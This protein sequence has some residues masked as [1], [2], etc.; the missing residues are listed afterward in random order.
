M[1]RILIATFIVLSLA[2]CKQ[3]GYV[4]TGD[5]LAPDQSLSLREQAEAAN[6]N[7]HDVAFGN[8]GDAT[9]LLDDIPVGAIIPHFG[10]WTFSA[11]WQICM[12]QEI[13]DPESPLYGRRVPDLVGAHTPFQTTYLAGTLDTGTYNRTFGNNTSA[14]GG[15]HGHGATSGGSRV[16]AG[17]DNGGDQ[18]FT[19]MGHQ[20]RVSDG[21]EHS[22]GDNRPHTY[23]IVYLIRIK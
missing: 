11:N 16:G 1:H 20:H 5:M 4:R 19:H 2:A 8:V 9:P 3:N 17:G 10:P 15:M 12:G 22:H 18:F 6:A 13:R 7:A 14:A 23:G 21:G